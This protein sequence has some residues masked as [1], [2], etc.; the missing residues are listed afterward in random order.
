MATNQRRPAQPA[1]LLAGLLD[2]GYAEATAQ[3]IRAIARDSSSGVIALRL[4]QLEARAAE[5]A[6][7]GLKLTA[8][9]PAL[10]ALLADFGDA[11][12]R[13]AVLI[14]AAGADLQEIAIN[15]AGEFVPGSA[16]GAPGVATRFN[17]PDPEAVQA[18]VEITGREAWRDEL[19]TFGEGADR[20]GQIALRGIVSG[21]GPLAI[22]RDMR[23]AVE[24][25][26]PWQANSLMRSLQLTTFRDAQAVV[27]AA[28][29]DLITGVIRVAALD[30]RTCFACWALHGTRLEVGERVVDHRQGR[31]TSVVEVLGQQVGVTTGPQLL[32]QMLSAERAGTLTARQTFVLSEM[33]ALHGASMRAVEAGA[34]RLED[35]VKR[36]VDPVFGEVVLEASLRGV[37]GEAARDYYRQ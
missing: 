15:A 9:D 19:A 34:A 20:V 14:D 24:G 12:R 4:N 3:V 23:Q 25:F 33:R 1:E 17:R 18:V 2:R 6:A 30:G 37:L 8:D 21:R 28:N 29:A 5:L 32:D 7:D 35:F 26:A 22:A 36:G 11:L 27:Q 13:E 16:I 31:C 10:R